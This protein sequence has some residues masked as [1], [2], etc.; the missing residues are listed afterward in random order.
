MRVHGECIVWFIYTKLQLAIARAVAKRI[1]KASG[2]FLFI[3]VSPNPA[4]LSLSA[5]VRSSVLPYL[6]VCLS[7]VTY[8]L[9]IT[10]SCP[11]KQIRIG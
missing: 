10:I 9:G 7:N 5:K 4:D 3:E 6:I 8:I 2:A 11:H 1:G